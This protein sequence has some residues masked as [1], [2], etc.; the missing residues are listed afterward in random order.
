MKLRRWNHKHAITALALCHWWWLTSADSID[1]T[2]PTNY[3]GGGRVRGQH[4]GFAAFG[5]ATRLR[6]TPLGGLQ[7]SVS[8]AL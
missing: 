2:G 1:D 8:S 4:S 5:C 6:S 3:P 7:M